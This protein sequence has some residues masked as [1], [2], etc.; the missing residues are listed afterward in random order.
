MDGLLFRK[1]V[2]CKVGLKES[3]CLDSKKNYQK[4]EQ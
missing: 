4:Y 2:D 3:A 1:E